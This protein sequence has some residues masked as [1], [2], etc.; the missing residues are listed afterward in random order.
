MVN[1]SP[2]F[3]ARSGEE[4]VFVSTMIRSPPLWNRKVC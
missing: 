4:A 1:S 3:G 2:Q